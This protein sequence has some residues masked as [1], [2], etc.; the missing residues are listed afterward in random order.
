MKKWICLTKNIRSLTYGKIYDA[1]FHFQFD[2]ILVVLDDF[3]LYIDVPLFVEEE[4]TSN[5]KFSVRRFG[6]LTKKTYNFMT[7]EE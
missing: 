4:D 7:I 2:N 1:R 6:P 3:G 5:Y